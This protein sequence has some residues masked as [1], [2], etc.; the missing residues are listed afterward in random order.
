MPKGPSTAR[1]ILLFE[2][3]PSLEAIVNALRRSFD[4]VRTDEAPVALVAYRPEVNGHVLAEVRA[5]RW[6][7]DTGALER[8][9]MMSSLCPDAAPAAEQHRAFVT[10][11]PDAPVMPDDHDALHEL[12]FI[13]SVA[14]AVLDVPGALAYFNPDGEVL[15]NTS[16]FDDYLT[17]QSRHGQVPID[18]WSNV[19]LIGRE[20]DA[21]WV[22]MD[23]IGMA[24]LGVQDVEACFPTTTH[25]P[26][27]VSAWLRNIAHY[28]LEKGPVIKPGDTTTGPGNV[29][30]QALP[31]DEPLLPAI[32]PTLRWF[33]AKLVAKA[34]EWTLE[35]LADE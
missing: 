28:L 18:L 33:P 10:L 11:R 3:T 26:N 32:R 34:P 1:A 12:R 29:P 2:N 23:T 24:Q 25:A 4:V 31:A 22:A 14:R 35:G 19:R 20:E 27:E 30:W 6:P 9:A 16:T 8:A 15:C 17:F 21:D 7:D 13:T 5:A